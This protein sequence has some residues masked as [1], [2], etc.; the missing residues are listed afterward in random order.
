MY[1]MK[2]LPEW[3]KLDNT[4][5]KVMKYIMQHGD[6]YNIASPFLYEEEHIQIIIWMW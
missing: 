2:V 1:T 3:L 6:V 5:G 4:M